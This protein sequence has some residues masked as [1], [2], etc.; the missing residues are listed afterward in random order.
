M[1]CR[2]L[3][4]FLQQ[5]ESQIYVCKNYEGLDMILMMFMISNSMV[6]MIIIMIMNSMVIM[7]N[8]VIMIIVMVRIIMMV[9]M[10]IEEFDIGWQMLITFCTL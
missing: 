5:N 8:M 6:I 10:V 2:V 7:I 1:F 9:M 4:K 3:I